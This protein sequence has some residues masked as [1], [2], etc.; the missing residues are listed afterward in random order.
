MSEGVHKKVLS[1]YSQAGYVTLEVLFTD[2]KSRA[3]FVLNNIELDL[4]KSYKT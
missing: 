4:V 1:A 2:V 3:D